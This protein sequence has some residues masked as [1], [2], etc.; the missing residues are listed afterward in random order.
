M[1]EIIHNFKCCINGNCG[2]CSMSG[3][4][5]ERELATEILGVVGTLYAEADILKDTVKQLENDNRE[6]R[7]RLKVKVKRCCK[8]CK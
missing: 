7:D 6:L 2:D 8:G 4:D 3:Y 1:K 5:C